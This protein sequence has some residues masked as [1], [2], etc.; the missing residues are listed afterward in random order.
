MKE[1]VAIFMLLVAVL[2]QDM[3]VLTL[4]DMGIGDIHVDPLDTEVR[5]SYFPS[6]KTGIATIN[7]TIYSEGSIMVI[8]TINNA[9][10]RVDNGGALKVRI[11]RNNTFTIKV[12]NVGLKKAI[13]YGNSTIAVTFTSQEK[14]QRNIS[15]FGLAF[16][17]SIVIPPV[18]IIL[19][20][21]KKV[22]HAEQTY[23]VM[24]ETW[25]S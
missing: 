22:E 6:S 15:G 17:L 18:I 9:S 23:E 13:V 21:R 24:P 14:T 7:I 5:T 4:S 2:G 20:R 19:V 10:K 3:R 12:I 16:I 8:V 11:E 1:I 25:P